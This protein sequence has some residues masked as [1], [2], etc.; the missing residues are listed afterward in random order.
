[1]KALFFDV[2]GTMV[3]WR[4]GVAREAQSILAPLGHPLD[5]IAFADACRAEYQ[6]AMAEVRSGRRP[7]RRLD[8]IR[9]RMLDTIGRASGSATSTRR[10]SRRS[11][12]PGIASMPGTT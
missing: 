5:W 12:S 11:S 1:M 6:P 10:R 3:D 2:F 7:F 4:S 8:V 9:R